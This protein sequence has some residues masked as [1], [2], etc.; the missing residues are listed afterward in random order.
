MTSTIKHPPLSLHNLSSSTGTADLAD[1]KVL[2]I[3]TEWNKTIIN[4]LLKFSVL[5]L[6]SLNLKDENIRIQSVP[7]SYEL[8]W[9]CNSVLSN[10]LIHKD[11]DAIIAMG[12]LIKGDTMHFEYISDAV[13]KK[14]M[15]VSIQHNKPIIFGVLTCL[16]EQQALI[17]SGLDPMS[18]SNHNHA[19][20]WAKAAVD[21]ALTS[22]RLSSSS[23]DL[24]H[25]ITAKDL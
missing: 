3:H 21:C 5:T 19:I 11:I 7:G 23:Q 17:R 2:I 22:R 1:L 24:P 13:S 14:L 16:T 9:A 20:D 4:N 25:F 15:D 8:P 18:P 10:P 6:Q 12:V